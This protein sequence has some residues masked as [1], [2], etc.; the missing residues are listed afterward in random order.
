MEPEHQAGS[1]FGFTKRIQ[2]GEAQ[3]CNVGNAKGTEHG[4]CKRLH[5]DLEDK[6]QNTEQKR[7]SVGSQTC[8]SDWSCRDHL[9]PQ[10]NQAGGGAVGSNEV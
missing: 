5:K 6:R 3:P 9:T 8:V 7:G 4:P 2:R 10:G 1:P